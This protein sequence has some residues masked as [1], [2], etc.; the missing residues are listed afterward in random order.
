D[1]AISGDAAGVRGVGVDTS[2]SIYSITSDW[3]FA[4]SGIANAITVSLAR[5]GSKIVWTAFTA[6]SDTAGP[7]FS[8]DFPSTLPTKIA[9]AKVVRIDPGFYATPRAARKY[10]VYATTFDPATFLSDLSYVP[11]DG[12]APPIV[13]SS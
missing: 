5:D 13:V 11:I 4:S 10:V 7:V 3:T 6:P 9:D 12:S 2:G 8:S 1:P